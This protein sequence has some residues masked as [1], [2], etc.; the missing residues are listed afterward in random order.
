M[1]CGG[2]YIVTGGHLWD[3]LPFCFFANHAGMLPTAYRK[4]VVQFDF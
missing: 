2:G 3:L 1:L 4:G